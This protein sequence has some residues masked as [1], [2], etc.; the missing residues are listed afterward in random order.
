MT[1]VKIPPTTPFPAADAGLA[2]LVALLTPTGVALYATFQGVQQVLA[3]IQVEALPGA[4]KVAG[5]GLLTVIGAATGVAG[6]VMGGALSDATRSR[7]GRRAPWL[8]GMALVSAFLIL[9][10][11][12][13]G[14][15]SIL[16]ALYGAAWFTLNFFQ[17][18]LLAVTPDRVPDAQR[19]RVSSI[20]GFAMPIGAL[21]GIAL[22]AHWPDARGYALLT[23]MLLVST[24]AFVTLCREPPFLGA[25]ANDNRR[26]RFGF[27]VSA[28]GSRDYALAFAFRTT[29]FV[30]Q[31]AINNYLLYALKDYV[32]VGHLPGGTAESAYGL[33]TLARTGATVLAIAAGGYWLA[34]TRRRKIFAQVYALTMTAAMLAPALSASWGAMLAFAVLGGLAIG[35]Y[36]AVDLALTTQVLPSRVSAGR[37]LAMLFMAGATAQFLAP[38]IGA[39]MIRGMGYGPL[40]FVGAALTLAAGLIASRL[41][42]VR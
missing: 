15:L 30:G 28:F 33:F 27:S 11:P 16:A 19:A 12:F 6:L 24:A 42:S 35:L 29:M 41:R 40:F 31:Y 17:G 14:A 36:G 38:P 32:G 22:A 39:F 2:R 9:A 8:A 37:D 20:F 23:A 13:A 26:A 3:P 10:M 7:F 4:D 5:V 21:S 1:P 34:R 25:A 18:A